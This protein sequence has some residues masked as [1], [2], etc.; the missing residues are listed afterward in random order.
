MGCD[1]EDDRCRPSTWGRTTR[2]PLQRSP[3]EGSGR[4]GRF[5]LDGRDAPSEHT[6]RKPTIGPRN[7]YF[8]DLVVAATE[9]GIRQVVLVATG[10]D[11]RAFRMPLPRDAVVFE[12]NE[13]PV[14]AEWQQVLDREGAEPVCRRIAVPAD[15]GK[16]TWPD[17]LLA[18]GF[19]R[20]LP[21]VSIAEGLTWYLSEDENAQL[22]D[23][24]AD[25]GRLRRRLGIDM[26]NADYLENRQSPPSSNCRCPRRPLQFG[27][28]THRASC[29]LIAGG[30]GGNFNEV[31]RRFGRWRPP[32]VS[33][34]VAARAVKA[35]RSFFITGA[36]ASS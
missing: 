11:T 30:G 3:G 18:A 32:G 27:T 36:R 13:E 9:A 7:R 21:A 12:V 8:D 22:L 15:L 35:S 31:G 23:H 1:G 29:L 20:S 19:E 2:P 25:L 28:N 6:G 34:E 17:L 33:E 14:L 4:R 5:S 24:L 10:M 26:V 16:D